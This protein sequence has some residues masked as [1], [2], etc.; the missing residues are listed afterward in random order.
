MVG[1]I[2]EPEIHRGSGVV[3]ADMIDTDNH[4]FGRFEFLG[5]SEDYWIV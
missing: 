4:W 3:Q 5:A 2:F 1:W